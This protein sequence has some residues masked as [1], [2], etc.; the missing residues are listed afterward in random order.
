MVKIAGTM[1]ALGAGCMLPERAV[2]QAWPSRP[3][4]LVVPYAPGGNVDIAARVFAKELSSKL[5]QQVVIENKSGAGGIV[6]SVAV[7]KAKPDGYT[8][9]LTAAGPA[10][11][12]KLLY[13]SIPYD[14]E[15]EFTPIVVTNDVPQILV[16]SPKLGIVTLKQLVDYARQKKS[17]TLGHAGPGTTGHLASLLLAAQTKMDA[18]LVAY[19]GAAPLISDVL[20]GQIDAGFPSYV[21]QVE[22]VTALGVTTDARLDFLPQVPTIGESGI[23]DVVAATWN[24]LLAPAGTPPDVVIKLNSIVNVFLTT[25]LAHQELAKLGA[26]PIGGT[27]EQVTKLITGD[28]ARWA[29]VIKAANIVLEQ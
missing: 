13:K 4:M 28:R 19:R 21:P 23:A 29:P 1:L 18:V 24:A 2:A 26:R 12:N 14:T 16:V 22:A 7:A 8:L 6:G 15:T 25:E 10:A 9:L 20:G 17:V 11:L 3:I 27:P 5:G